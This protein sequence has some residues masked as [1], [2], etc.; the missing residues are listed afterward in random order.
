MD[1]S[2]Y[3][4]KRLEYEV[5]SLDETKVPSNPFDLFNDWLSEVA[6][7]GEIEPTAMHL[8]TLGADGSPDGRIVL[9][10]KVDTNSL[11]FFTNLKSKKARDLETNPLASATFFWAI[12]QRQ[13]RVQ[14]RVE[15]LSDSESDQY[16]SQRPYESQLAAH[17]SQQSSI[18]PDRQALEDAMESIRKNF[19]SDVPRPEFWG[20]YRLISNRFEFWQGRR[21]R[22][23]DRILYTR[24][25]DR[26]NIS[27]L[28]P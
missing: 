27:R 4:G 9:L 16:F 20:G 13:V 7:S 12:L 28:A 22:L 21:S 15:R 5:G 3:L 8:S 11:Q 14:G 2:P 23:H 18:L 25:A 24:A 6:L 17:A 1:E 10:R 19:P 26:W